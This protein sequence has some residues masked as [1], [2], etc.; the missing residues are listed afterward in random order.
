M[1]KVEKL[2]YRYGTDSD[3]AKA[4]DNIE[5]HI[6]QGE[7]VAIVGS[8]GSGKSTLSKHFNALLLPTE[9]QVIVDGL[10]TQ[11]MEHL[12]EIRQKVGMVFQNPDNQIVAGVVE[13][14]VAFGP[15]N[16]GLPSE[17]IRTRVADA[18]KRVGMWDYRKYGPHQL[19][20]GQ[21]QR[22][23]IA[24][25][26]AMRPAC[27]VLDEATAMLDPLGRKEVMDTVRRLNKEEGITVIY[28]THFMDEA[29][30]AGRVIA[31]L[32]GKIA[33]DGS[34]RHVFNQTG[35]IRALGLDV[36]AVAALAKALRTEGILVPQDILT[37]DEMVVSLCRWN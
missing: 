12:W 11:Q 8:N 27:I 2:V 23:A 28:I 24:G 21:K 7:F 31:M 1:I 22:V 36:P 6:K 3:G 16:I 34:A 32:D 25:I 9:G 29:V 18:L 33:L 19:S 30:Q 5:L 20:G 10:N 14:D 37:V 35:T 4:L 15:E 17:Q 26:I 13:E